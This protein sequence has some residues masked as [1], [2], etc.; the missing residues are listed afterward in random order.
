MDLEPSGTEVPFPVFQHTE[1]NVNRAAWGPVHGLTD[2][3]FV[4]DAHVK[5]GDSNLAHFKVEPGFSQT[6]VY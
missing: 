1:H 2:I 3:C 6:P 5:D 4:V